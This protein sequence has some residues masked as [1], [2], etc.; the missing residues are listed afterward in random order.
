MSQDDFCKTFAA[1]VRSKVAE[2][3]AD[4]RLHSIESDPD[5]EWPLVTICHNTASVIC[6]GCGYHV[7]TGLG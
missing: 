1:W 6:P 3:R 4:S 2:L 7:G 5:G